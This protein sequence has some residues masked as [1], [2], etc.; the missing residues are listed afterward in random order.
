MSYN[1]SINISAEDRAAIDDAV[2][3]RFYLR[4][5]EQGRSFIELDADYRDT[6]EF[7]LQTAYDHRD[8]AISPPKEYEPEQGLLYALQNEI[9]ES[10]E[11]YRWN[12][13]DELLRCAGFDPDDDKA[14]PQ[15][16]YL[17]ETYPITPPYDHYLDQTMLVNII[18]GTPSEIDDGFGVIHDQI[19]AMTRPEDL[20]DSS[21]ANIR[22]LL[23]EDSSLK[24]LV[25][26][27]GYTMDDLVS[28]M[29]DF[30][31]DFYDPDG[32]PAKYCDENGKSLPCE[33]RMDLFTAG[34]SKFLT[35]LCEELDN[36][37]YTMGAITVLA[38]VSMNDF[39]E[40]M[41]PGKEITVSSDCMLGI[42]GPWVGAGSQLGIYLSKNL[43]FSR[44][45]IH[46][47]Q[48]EGAKMDNYS[49]DS[50]YGMTKEAW[51]GKV[52]VQD[53][54]PDRHPALDD[55]IG[56]AA[57]RAGMKTAEQQGKD[58]LTR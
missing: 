38:E 28:T 45:D 46:D 25:E 21:P 12:T 42:F 5:D 9:D 41:K 1:E 23:D 52:S 30:M 8:D 4:K 50:V 37:C 32:H 24:R 40:M 10:Y 6:N 44:E 29:K 47:V 53:K 3:R 20:T 14:E 22:R 31:K 36:H 13:E 48:I 26:Q 33:T 18:L 39:I 43:V 2:Q 49:V 15:K 57:Q 19:V 17:R 27:Q 55:I 35:S 34:R 51:R 11:E 16:D 7:L 58:D 56:S 54:A